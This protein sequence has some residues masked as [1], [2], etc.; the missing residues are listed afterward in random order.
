M[1]EYLRNV[2]LQY[3]KDYCN[4]VK[5]SEMEDVLYMIPTI[6]HYLDLRDY[7]I[8]Y[9]AR[10]LKSTLTIDICQ[11]GED[12][13]IGIIRIH[14]GKMF[15]L[16]KS[17]TFVDNLETNKRDI[18]GTYMEST[19]RGL[20]TIKYDK[21]GINATFGGYYKYYS[22]YPIERID[23]LCDCINQYGGRSRQ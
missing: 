6:V 2:Y 11:K 22:N 5:K 14:P 8:L 15:V 23:Q 17:K 12:E 13:P 7:Y 20:Q 3:C 19:S 16:V 9:D 18:S 10:Y 21:K 1:E 4:L